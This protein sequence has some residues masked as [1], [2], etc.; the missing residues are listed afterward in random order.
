MHWRQRTAGGRPGRSPAERIEERRGRRAQAVARA[1]TQLVAS[2]VAVTY[3]RVAGRTGL[4]EGYL[5]WA[6]PTAADLVAAGAQPHGGVSALP[7]TSHHSDV[8]VE[9]M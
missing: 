4:P 2:G 6:H 3:E 9:M 5:R 7:Q 8:I 1:V